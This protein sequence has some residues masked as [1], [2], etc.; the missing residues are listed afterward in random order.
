MRKVQPV[1]LLI[2]IVQLVI[3]KTV[4]VQ[5]VIVKTAQIAQAVIVQTAVIVVK[6]Y[7]IRQIKENLITNRDK[8]VVLNI[9]VNNVKVVMDMLGL[10]V[11]LRGVGVFVIIS[12]AKKI[13]IE[14]YAIGF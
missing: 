7:S 12:G 6:I 1:L 8:V 4:I 9:V 5:A 14:E 3:A 13:P 2:V 11:V 10:L